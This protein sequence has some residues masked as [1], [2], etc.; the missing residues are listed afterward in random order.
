MTNALKENS[1]SIRSTEGKFSRDSPLR[2]QTGKRYELRPEHTENAS[3]AMNV[4]G[5]VAERK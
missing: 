2:L 4:S 5:G 1:F 3:Q